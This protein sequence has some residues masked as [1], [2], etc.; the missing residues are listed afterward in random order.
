MLLAVIIDLTFS[1]N[2]ANPLPLGSLR[3]LT[4]GC[5][6]AATPYVA[7]R[8]HS[9]GTP[10]AF[11]GEREQ[12]RSTRQRQDNSIIIENTLQTIRCRATPF[13]SSSTNGH[14]T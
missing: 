4:N 13:P 11:N 10:A 6:A 12:Q 9:S 1:G 8:Q 2:T 14:P 5:F 7:P 3:P